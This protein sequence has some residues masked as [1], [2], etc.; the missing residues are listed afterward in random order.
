MDREGP[1][2]ALARYNA[3]YLSLCTYE[4][5]SLVDLSCLTVAVFKGHSVFDDQTHWISSILLI[6]P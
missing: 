2:V 5:A 1:L 3:T 4:N 6:W